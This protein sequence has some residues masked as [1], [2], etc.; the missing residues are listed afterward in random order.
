[1]KHSIYNYIGHEIIISLA[2]LIYFLSKRPT[3][4]T[5]IINTTRP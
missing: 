4:V 3:L 1:M 2:K 5:L